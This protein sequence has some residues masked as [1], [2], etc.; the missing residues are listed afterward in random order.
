MI[1]VVVSVLR[2]RCLSYPVWSADTWFYWLRVSFH[3]EAIHHAVN[4][5]VEPATNSH[6]FTCNFKFLTKLP[7][8]NTWLRLIVISRWFEVRAVIGSIGKLTELTSYW[9]LIFTSLLKIIGL[10][11]KDN[12]RCVLEFNR[13]SCF[14]LKHRLSKSHNTL[15]ELAPGCKFSFC[16]FTCFHVILT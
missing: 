6:N 14:F 1:P 10:L 12:L 15:F 13:T 11:S 16:A 7:I 2:G 8:F 9:W 3:D 4:H 5:R